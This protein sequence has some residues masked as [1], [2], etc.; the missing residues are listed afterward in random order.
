MQIAD[1]FL[2]FC[3]VGHLSGRIVMGDF[4]IWENENDTWRQIITQ[5]LLWVL[6]VNS[7]VYLVRQLPGSQSNSFIVTLYLM[8]KRRKKIV[9]YIIYCA[10]YWVFWG[11]TSGLWPFHRP[12]FPDMDEG[13][14]KLPSVEILIFM[15]QPLC[16]DVKQTK[17][18]RYPIVL[19]FCLYSFPLFLSL[20]QKD[21]QSHFTSW[22]SQS[23][24]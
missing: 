22:R 4:Q 5:T 7:V 9:H 11:A 3:A 12:S 8:G 17:T 1:G 21:H 16:G 10:V 15:W 23:N 13:Y 24:L 2:D 20:F 14:S 6:N 18:V 19:I